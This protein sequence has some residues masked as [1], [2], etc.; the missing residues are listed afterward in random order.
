MISYSKDDIDC[1]KRLINS[2]INSFNLKSNEDDEE[3]GIKVPINKTNVVTG[4]KLRNIQSITLSQTKDYLSKT[5]GPM[6][7]NTKI[8]KGQN[9]AEI[10]S[11][12]IDRIGG[13]PTYSKDIN[14]LV[15]T[16]DNTNS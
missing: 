15:L 3:L 16:R 9:Q 6:G 2:G 13:F 1:V 4:E 11:S 10:T 7:S 5:F 14:T 8:I 12:Y